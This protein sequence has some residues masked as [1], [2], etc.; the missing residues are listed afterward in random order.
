MFS[1]R[2]LVSGGSANKG[3]Q[4]K[5]ATNDTLSLYAVGQKGLGHIMHLEKT[6][7]LEAKLDFFSRVG[8]ANNGT[9]E[10][11]LINL[12]RRST[13]KKAAQGISLDNWKTI[14]LLNI[15]LLSYRFCANWAD[16]L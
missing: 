9:R 6:N 13:L 12:E 14:I 2:N 16:L 8:A 7:E 10:T 15:N 4:L 11:S 3:S 5:L 1:E